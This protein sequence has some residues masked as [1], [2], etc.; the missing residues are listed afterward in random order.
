MQ[1]C[2]EHFYGNVRVDAKDEVN[3]FDAHLIIVSGLGQIH[4]FHGIMVLRD[5]VISP[6]VVRDVK[7]GDLVLCPMSIMEEY[8]DYIQEYA[9][10]Y[11]L[12]P[13]VIVEQVFL[14]SSGAEQCLIE[15]SVGFEVEHVLY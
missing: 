2:F 13:P 7:V 15:E 12:P 9:K 4:V 10:H 6:R 5:G 8:G 3:Y 14:A 1:N 11:E